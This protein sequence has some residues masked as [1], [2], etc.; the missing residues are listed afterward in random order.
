MVMCML[1][2]SYV[3]TGNIVKIC[4]LKQEKFENYG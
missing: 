3:I 2:K 1:S 4:V